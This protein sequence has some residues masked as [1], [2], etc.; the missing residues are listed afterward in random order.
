VFPSNSGQLAPSIAG[1][2]GLALTEKVLN[3]KLPTDLK[4]LLIEIN[5]DN[6]LV[7]STE[8][9]IK[10]RRGYNANQAFNNLDISIC[11]YNNYNDCIAGIAG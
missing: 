7:F 9:I 8:Q 3:C 10:T 11:T 4:E 1:H 5:G 6:W 2:Y